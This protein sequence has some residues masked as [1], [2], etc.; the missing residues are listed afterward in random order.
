MS[1]DP[2]NAKLWWPDLITSTPNYPNLLPICW[3]SFP[4]G[5]KPSETIPELY[6]PRPLLVF[7]AQKV[8]SA[9]GLSSA[10]LQLI[11]AMGTSGWDGDESDFEEDDLRIEYLLKPDDNSQQ[12]LK[13]FKLITGLWK[14][15]LFQFDLLNILYYNSDWFQIPSYRPPP[16]PPVH[17]PQIGFFPPAQEGRLDKVLYGEDGKDTRFTNRV[18]ALLAP[19]K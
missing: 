15:T 13:R 3:G 18:K 4:Y 9:K 16:L 17:A 19:S 2:K 7:M 5:G 14:P 11:V 6:K 8:P 1:Y 12:A 10:A